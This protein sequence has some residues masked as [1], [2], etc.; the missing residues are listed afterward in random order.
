MP[1]IAKVTH[2]QLTPAYP[3]NLFPGPSLGKEQGQRGTAAATAMHRAIKYQLGGRSN[4]GC[5]GYNFT[6]KYTFAPTPPHAEAGSSLHSRAP[7]PAGMPPGVQRGGTATAAD[8]TPVGWPWWHPRC[9]VLAAAAGP[10]R[11][12]PCRAEAAPGGLTATQGRWPRWPQGQR[13]LLQQGRCLGAGTPQGRWRP[14]ALLL[15]P[16]L[17]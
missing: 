1:P 2:V 5:C 12:T 6:G 10:R 17:F 11:T 9:S 14:L 8:D 4:R 7:L 15:T 16:A 3:F 13:P